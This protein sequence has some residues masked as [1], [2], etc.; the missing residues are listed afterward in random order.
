[1]EACKRYGEF[2]LP[3]LDEVA[4]NLGGA[5]AETK[6]VLLVKLPGKKEMVRS[7]AEAAPREKVH[8]PAPKEEYARLV[9]DAERLHGNIE[10]Y[11]KGKRR[12]QPTQ[13]TRE[14]YIRHY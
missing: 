7:S 13:P 3:E 12:D 14:E 1:M 2:T 5:I 9:K 10:K 6:P 4:S 8:D 11:M